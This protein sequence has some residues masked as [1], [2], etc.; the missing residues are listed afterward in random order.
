[1]QK[2]NILKEWI[3]VISKKMKQKNNYDASEHNFDELKISS[4]SI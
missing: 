4:S 2:S 1:M 3:S